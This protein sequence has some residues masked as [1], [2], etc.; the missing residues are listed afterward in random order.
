MSQGNFLKI[1]AKN[2]KFFEIKFLYAF[3][4]IKGWGRFYKTIKILLFQN[5]EKVR[6]K[7]E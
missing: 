3:K 1:Y 5:V 7:L 2:G 6:L 4:K